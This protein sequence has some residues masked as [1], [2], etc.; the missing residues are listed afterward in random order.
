MNANILHRNTDANYLYMERFV[1]NGSPSGFTFK[2]STSPE[3]NP[4]TGED[5]FHLWN[6]SDALADSVIE[7]GSVP[8]FFRGVNYAHPDSRKAGILC[9]A[10]IPLSESSILVSPLAS[11]RT[12]QLRNS[13]PGFLKLTYDSG[14]LGRCTRYLGKISCLASYETSC[15]IMEQVAKGCFPSTFAFY[16]ESG[17]KVSLLK[18]RKE[19]FEFGTIFRQPYPSPIC[20]EPRI[21]IPAFSLFGVDF[22]NKDDDY[23]LIQLIEHS[24]LSPIDYTLTLL[25][26]A[27]DAFWLLLTKCALIPELHGQNCVYELDHNFVPVRFCVKDMEDIDREML[28]A[29][30]LGLKTEWESYPYKCNDEN[31][32][33]R[34]YRASY[35]YDFKLGEYLLKPIIE[36]VSERYSISASFF[37]SHIQEYVRQQYL[38][39][40]PYDLFPND[41]WYYRTNEASTASATKKYHVAE[42][43]KFR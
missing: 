13:I 27:V 8:E 9:Q 21:L 3:T 11:G 1:N 5:V 42:N 16:E 36:I 24:K 23:L 35:L 4:F 14:I 7:I 38:S 40:I 26:L 10:G 6:F 15:Y 37:A 33:D 29:K 32:S 18:H 20:Y 41:I 34:V 30:E 39:S 28:L 19:I 12:V 2:H 17:M 22:K 31:V 25:H 43:P